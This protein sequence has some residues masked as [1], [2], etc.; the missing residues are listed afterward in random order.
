MV[1]PF[2][3]AGGGR[4]SARSTL[5]IVFLG[6]EESAASTGWLV[7]TS[8]GRILVST[9]GGARDVVTPPLDLNAMRLELRL[10]KHSLSRLRR[11]LTAC[12]LL[13]SGL[14]VSAQDRPNI[15]MIA[16]DDLKPTIAAYGDAIVHSPN[17]DR[18]AAAGMTFTNAHCQQAVCGPSRAS[19]LT[20]LRPDQTRVWDLK[21]KIRVE[22]PEVV[23]LPQ[24]FRLNGY[25]SVGVG[26]I[27]DFRSV[28]G[29]HERDDPASW[30][31]PYVVF[32]ENPESEMGILDPDFIARVRE[33]REQ[34]GD[35]AT[36]DKVR[37]AVGGVPPFEGDQDVPDE[38]YDDGNIAATAVDL[39]EELAPR[40]EPFFLAVGFKK[41]HLPFVA[42]KKYWDLY[43]T[44][45]FSPD[46]QRNPPVGAPAYHFQTGWELRNGAYSDVPLL[47]DP[48]G[49]PDE[50]AVKL[51]HGYYACVSY[52]DAQVG[53]VL[54]ALEAS[55]EADNTIIAVWGD[56]GYH[57]GDHGIWCKH[58]NYEQATRVPFLIIDPRKGKTARGNKSAVPVELLDLYPTLCEMAGLPVPEQLQGASLRPTLE[59]PAKAVKP[60]A[61]SQFPRTLEGREI[62]GY[63]W[64]TDRYRYIEWIDNGFRE[65]GRSGPILDIE[66]YDYEMDPKETRNLADDP[67]YADVL[68]VMQQHAS[69]HKTQQFGAES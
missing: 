32:P 11:S 62:M 50:T 29:G 38:A 51:I 39:I 18:L 57:L 60:Y 23:T 33:T 9:P 48:G 35:R 44:A 66:L 46:P 58:T 10:P 69:D 16:V 13:L 21:T 4:K 12:A 37:T 34:L 56:H 67:A 63:S 49:I 5:R 40:D 27:F 20:G 3:K 19:L 43:D 42:P 26:K 30:S 22:N 31:R 41:P 6:W 59:K 24:Y 52:M 17:L 45:Q 36:W 53:K 8:T 54:A 55:G 64:R 65:G 1:R 15:L 14:A 2:V 61:V 47:S 7:N 25:E 68:A 28:E